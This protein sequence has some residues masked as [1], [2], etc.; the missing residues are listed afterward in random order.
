VGVPASTVA[1]HRQTATFSHNYF[2]S[3]RKI[4]CAKMGASLHV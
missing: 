4:V 2:H 1:Q 3:H